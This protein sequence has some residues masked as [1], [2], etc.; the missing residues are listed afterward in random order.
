MG[1]LIIYLEWAI[2]FYIFSFVFVIGFSY[3]IYKAKVRS[4][5]DVFFYLGSFI[6]MIFIFGLT[7]GNSDFQHIKI[8]NIIQNL[9][10][11]N[12]IPFIGLLSVFL[13][14]IN[15]NTKEF[16][17][18]FGNIVL[19]IPIGFFYGAFFLNSKN[20]YKHIILLGIISSLVIEIFQIFGLRAFDIND[21]ILNTLGV[22]IGFYILNALKIYNIK[23]ITKI[24]INISKDKLTFTVMNLLII[25]CQISFILIEII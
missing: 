2:G 17:N 4:K 24:E 9:N 18:F 19:F 8:N 21:I 20:K 25:I 3:Y 13:F 7:I 14:A 5:V 23:P 1:N 11:I 22:Y 12:L 16:I 10:T 15:G 6:S